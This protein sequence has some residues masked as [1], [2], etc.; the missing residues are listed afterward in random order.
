MSV[1][2]L[3]LRILLILSGCTDLTKLFM[4]SNRFEEPGRIHSPPFYSKITLQEVPMIKLFSLNMLEITSYLFKFMLM[5]SFLVQQTQ[6]CVMN[7]RKSCDLKLR[8]V[9]WE[10]YSTF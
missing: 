3:G 8:C 9:P 7:L 10:N 5:I 2:H 6:N 4:G 1:S